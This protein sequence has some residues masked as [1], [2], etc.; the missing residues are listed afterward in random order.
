MGGASV[1][2][3]DRYPGTDLHRI[4]GGLSFF[5]NHGVVN[6]I[7]QGL[8]STF[9]KGQFIL[10]LFV[11]GVADSA[12]PFPGLVDPL[13][14]VLATNSTEV[15]QLRLQLFQPFSCQIHWLRH[16]HTVRF[17]QEILE[18]IMG[19]MTRGPSLLV[20]DCNPQSLPCKAVRMG[21]LRQIA[22]GKK[23]KGMIS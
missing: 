16:N 20:H 1:L 4:S 14:H 5:N 3:L 17:K 6:Y 22:S 21:T 15:I 18:N 12:S 23:P 9:G 2:V 11:F 7:V 13:G 19:E 8:D 10:G